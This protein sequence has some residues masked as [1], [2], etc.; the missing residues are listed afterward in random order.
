MFAYRLFLTVCMLYTASFAGAEEAEPQPRIIGAAW[1]YSINGNYE[2]VK[3]DLVDAIESRGIVISYVA[4]A[5]SMLQRTSEAVGAVGKAYDR[6][7][8]LLFC[9]ADL[10]YQ[11][12]I[13]NPHNLALCPYSVSIYTL[14]GDWE[15]VYLSIRAPE[16]NV[17][18]YGAVHQLLIDIIDDTISW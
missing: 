10:T 11:L 8:I 17:P 15:N 3:I 6:A 16:P 1:V 18:E 14:A 12:T 2:D 7:D 9:K 5:A 13:K 4:H